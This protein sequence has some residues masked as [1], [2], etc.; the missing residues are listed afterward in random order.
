MPLVSLSEVEQPNMFDRAT[1]RFVHRRW[2]Q[3]LCVAGRLPEDHAGL[4]ALAVAIGLRL[5]V[6]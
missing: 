2:H 3:S 1:L 4:F 5:W 6:L